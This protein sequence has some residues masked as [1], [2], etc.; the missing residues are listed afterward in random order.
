MKLG[1]L[2]HGFIEWGGG[3]DFL[4]GVC[5]SLAAADPGN[6]LH[7][8]LPARGP[9]LQARRVWH[10]AR[11]VARRALGQP[12]ANQ[13]KPDLQLV[14]EVLQSQSGSLR[15]H[16][17]DAGSAAVASAVQRLALCAVLPSVQPFGTGL[18]VPWLGYIAD[19]Q[20]AHLPQFF[21]AKEIQARNTN[22]ADML[23]RA[24]GVIVNA[25]SVAQDIE[26]FLPGRAARVT[27]LPFSAAPDP[28]WF[29]TNEPPLAH[30]GVNGPYFI[31]S[32][33]FW[34]HKD[35]L[36]A[37]RAFSRVLRQH[38][39]LSLVCTGETSDHRNPGH[40]AMLCREA[41]AL[42]INRRLYVPG[43]IPKRDQ[44][45]LLRGA[46]AVV[47][48]TLFEGGPGGGSVFDAVALG[49][50]AIVSDV[51]VNLEIAEPEVSFFKASDVAA[52]AAAMSARAAAGHAVR[53][54]AAELIAAGQRRRQACG[55]VLL[56]AVDRLR[57]AA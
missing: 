29:S 56:E 38:P 10:G 31:I 49:L 51:A 34:Q 3:L 48:P 7:L 21:S 53:P 39:G 44:I 57:R 25:R 36:C 22:F 43:L 5:G 19:F 41:Q 4:R 24:P 42:G 12:V 23:Q 28:S 30:Y 17:I 46:L 50:P 26:R 27:A 16:E 11:Q 40:F 45:A 9:R 20:H 32:N 35:H 47:Q 1:I 6:E 33:Q 37:Y 52:L 8:L 14:R 13:R 54:G 55:R 2:G 15:I 18:S